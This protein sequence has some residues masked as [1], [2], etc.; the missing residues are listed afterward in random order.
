MDLV[1]HGSEV[2][3]SV[4]SVEPHDGTIRLLP[5]IDKVKLQLP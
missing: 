1:H 2:G 3:K 5:F 4:F